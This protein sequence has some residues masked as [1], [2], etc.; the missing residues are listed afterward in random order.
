[1]VATQTL[2]VIFTISIK[3]CKPI[4][5]DFNVLK[6]KVFHSLY[7]KENMKKKIN[8]QYQSLMKMVNWF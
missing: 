8:M 4:S 3:I 2:M 5:T 1:M 6:A 7:E